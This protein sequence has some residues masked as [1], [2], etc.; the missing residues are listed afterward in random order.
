MDSRSMTYGAWLSLCFTRSHPVWSVL[1]MDIDLLSIYGKANGSWISLKQGLTTEKVILYSV[2]FTLTEDT[3]LSLKKVVIRWKI[4]G[5]HQEW[6]D[7][8]A[9][10]VLHSRPDL[11]NELLRHCITP[12]AISTLWELTLLGGTGGRR[13]DFLWMLNLP[14][15]NVE[16]P[17]LLPNQPTF[18]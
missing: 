4:W 10:S 11:P 13:Q 6:E 9:Q 3:G 2:P 17:G 18:M 15:L 14:N 12:S 1:F 7:T 16:T 8:L 5:G